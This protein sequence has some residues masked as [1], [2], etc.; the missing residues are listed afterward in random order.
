[1]RP[2]ALLLLWLGLWFCLGG[3]A[4]ASAR[5]ILKAV[6]PVV[7]FGSQQQYQF[8]AR[9]D[10]GATLSSIDSRLAQR[11]GLDQQPL[12]EILVQNAHGTT[13]RRVIKVKYIL[14]GQLR[15]SDFTLIS[16]QDLPYPILLGRRSLT[17]FLVDPSEPESAKQP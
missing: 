13:R 5:P 17:G 16:R 3:P 14:K 7:I 8:K 9:I 2:R 4:G 15:E 1:M 6:E 10:T 11:L 12:R